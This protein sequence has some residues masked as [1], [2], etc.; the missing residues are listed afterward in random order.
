MSA[1]LAWVQGLHPQRVACARG[2]GC[3]LLWVQGLHQQRVACAR[4]PGCCRSGVAAQRGC[5]S[6]RLGRRRN[7]VAIA[8]HAPWRCRQVA[9]Y[10]RAADCCVT[11][12]PL[13]V[14]SVVTR[15]R[16][17]CLMRTGWRCP[18]RT[19]CTS[20]TAAGP[21]SRASRRWAAGRLC[22]RAVR[23][24]RGCLSGRG[25][26]SAVQSRQGWTESL[27]PCGLHRVQPCLGTGNRQPLWLSWLF[28]WSHTLPA[29]H[30]RS[31]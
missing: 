18:P 29:R 4:G 19:A 5:M 17:V 3:W 2:P 25:C 9:S 10:A 22:S 20:G 1:G 31:S 28:S 30:C 6:A 24:G 11:P 7:R 15:T 26:F 8:E 23:D 13:T 21:T 14:L 27:S 12:L 16:A